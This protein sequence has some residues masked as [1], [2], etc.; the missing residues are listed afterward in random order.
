LLYFVQLTKVVGVF[1]FV[2]RFTNLTLQSLLKEDAV[3]GPAPAPW[4]TP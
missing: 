1:I 3:A 2:R 4:A